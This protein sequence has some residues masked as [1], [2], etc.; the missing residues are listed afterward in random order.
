MQ[1]TVELQKSFSY[2]PLLLYLLAGV[3]GVVLIIF[4]PK[5]RKKQNT[6]PVFLKPQPLPPQNIASLKN[7]YTALLSDLAKRCSENKLSHRKAFQ[8]LSK[9]VRDFVFEATGIQV[10]YYTLSEIQV[11]GLPKLYELISECYA[12]EFSRK[13]NSNVYE[14][15][16]KARKVIEEWN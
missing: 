1:I 15:I 12:P 4:W 2:L 5:K 8:K 3:L 13:S 14:A 7:K 10:Q 9:I 6:G 16:N 11:A